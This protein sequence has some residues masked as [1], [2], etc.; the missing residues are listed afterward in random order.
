ME[1]LDGLDNLEYKMKLKVSSKFSEIVKEVNDGFNK[2]L[3]IVVLSAESLEEVLM[4][5]ITKTKEQ[6][7]N[8]LQTNNTLDK[9]RN[10]ISKDINIS[11]D[12]SLEYETKTQIDKKASKYVSRTNFEA[13]ILKDTTDKDNLVGEIENAN[14]FDLD[15]FSPSVK[16]ESD[17]SNKKGYEF[18][19]TAN[20]KIIKNDKTQSKIFECDSCVYTSRYKQQLVEHINSKHENIKQYV[21]I[22]CEY[23]TA[24]KGNLTSHMQNKHKEI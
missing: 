1:I 24:K 11:E 6:Q 5:E 19:Q 4:T 23:S 16:A 3:Q 9:K 7:I 18:E 12:I 17:S 8:V 20:S 21:C 2:L 10:R 22:R 14:S 13:N 15:Y